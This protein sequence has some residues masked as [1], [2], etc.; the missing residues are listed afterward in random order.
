MRNLF[1]RLCQAGRRNEGLGELLVAGG[2]GQP[3]DALLHLLDGVALPEHGFHVAE[4]RFDTVE[5]LH[6][7]AVVLSVGLDELLEAFGGQWFRHKRGVR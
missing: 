3:H 2:A 1:D 6:D 4:T 5:A 7:V